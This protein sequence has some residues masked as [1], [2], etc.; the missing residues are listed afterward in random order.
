MSGT[1]DPELEDSPL[2]DG[3]LEELFKRFAGN[4][5][6]YAMSRLTRGDHTRS[7]DIVQDTFVA[8]AAAWAE[9]GT[10]LPG[11][12]EAWLLRVALNKAV[13]FWRRSNR[14]TPGLDPITDTLR[15]PDDVC[16]Q[17]LCAIALRECWN[18]IE[19]MPPRQQQVAL[20]R[21][22]EGR[23][24]GDIATRLKINQSTVRVHLN[25]ARQQL[26]HKVGS[27]VPFTLEQHP[28]GTRHTDSGADE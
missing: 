15:A 2:A 27:A 5:Y 23:N 24:T 19:G 3:E 9:V 28:P 18:I 22:R 16:H 4:V 8:A 20:L 6:R 7:E 1:G 13:D 25:K 17:A 21:W 14:V 26:R 11:E 10:L 12:Q